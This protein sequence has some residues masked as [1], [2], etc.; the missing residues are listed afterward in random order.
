MS[1]G[2]YHENFSSKTHAITDSIPFC[3]IAYELYNRFR[4]T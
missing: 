3:S 1:K 4:C 2:S